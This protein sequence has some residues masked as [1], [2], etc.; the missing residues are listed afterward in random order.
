[1]IGRFYVL[2]PWGVLG[3]DVMGATGSPHSVLAFPA[4]SPGWP[5]SPYE[6]WSKLL[7]GGYIGII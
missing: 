5:V 4:K 3:R 1:M 7:K 6:L 2:D